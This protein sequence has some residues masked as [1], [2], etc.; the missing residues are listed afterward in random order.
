MVF[1]ANLWTLSAVTTYIYFEERLDPSMQY[2]DHSKATLV[3]S[4]PST[5]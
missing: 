5:F 2:I 4:E 1:L 3:S